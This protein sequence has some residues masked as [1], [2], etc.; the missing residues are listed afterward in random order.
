M[1]EERTSDK[2]AEDYT[3]MGHSI[4]LINGIIGG[5]IDADEPAE[6]RQDIVD[7]NTSHLTTMIAKEDWDGEDMTAANSSITA[8]NNYTAS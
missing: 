7:R 3:A 2:R 5:S 6:D 4:T 1:S 8:G